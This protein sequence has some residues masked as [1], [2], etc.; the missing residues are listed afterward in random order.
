MTDKVKS[1][2][3]LRV[4]LSQL[5]RFFSRGVKIRLALISLFSIVL[6]LMETAG[7]MLVL[8]LV[9]LAVGKNTL[10]AVA[11]DIASDLGLN[12]NRKLGVALVCAVVGIFILKDLGS[13]W[14]N[15][16][17]SRFLAVQRVETQ[18]RMM[19]GY[20]SLP[21]QEYRKYSTAEI[22]RTF[23]DA[24]D[25]L[26]GSVVGGLI[27]LVS[28]VFSVISIFFALFFAIPVPTLVIMI[29]F[30]IG[31]GFYMRFVRPRTTG[32]GEMIMEASV[33]SYLSAL[34]GL[35]AYK[36]ITLRHTEKYFTKNYKRA[37]INVAEAGRVA[38]FYSA[39]PRFLLEI[40]F[41]SAVG[42]LLFYMFIVGDQGSAVGSM[43]LLVAAGF[44]ILPNI[45]AIISAVNSVRLGA[46][47][48]DIVFKESAVATRNLLPQHKELRRMEY[49]KEI[50]LQNV[51]FGYS[52]SDG[53]V[54]KGVSLNIPYG[55]SV[56]FVGGSGAG[57]TTLVD[58]IL[59]LLRPTSGVVLVDGQDISDNPRS[60]QENTSM[61]AQDVYVSGRS[62][63]ENIIFDEPVELADQEQLKATVERAQLADLVASLPEGLDTLCGE[64]GTRL[65]GGQRQRIGI[66]RAL[67]RNPS[68]LV[69][70]EAT[71][72]LDN[73]TEKKITDTI[74]SLSGG[75]TVV[76]VAHRLS[77]VKNVDQVVYLENGQ[78]AGIG[79]FRELQKTN[80]KFAQLVALGKLD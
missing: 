7:I 76:V 62:V 59:G 35:G 8:P 33:Q 70:D 77:T 18:Y 5:N 67:Y 38:E 47:S 63:R 25:R 4:T 20:M 15:W 78:I 60:W 79:S 12:T 51:R 30:S 24:V 42:L 28:A 56:A 57:K 36:E 71:S 74:D 22:I 32:A 3:S 29:Y 14:F 26:Y 19:E 73:E 21:W 50:S 13:I 41:M 34:H 31:A 23:R 2:L 64:R 17:K 37:A 46:G 48:L 9:D 44:R 52:D 58:I 53:E 45:S 40:I 27:S 43:A 68:L 75:V 72:A 49:S 39:I 80:E 11:A 61:V 65:S 10:P 6:G 66:A 55:S 1:E 16:W 69:L 54:V